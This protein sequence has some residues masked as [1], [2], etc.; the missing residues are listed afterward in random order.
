MNKNFPVS[1]RT[2]IFKFKKLYVCLGL[3]HLPYFVCQKM[4]TLVHFIQNFRPGPLKWAFFAY[5][6]YA[7]NKSNDFSYLPTISLSHCIPKQ[8][9]NYFALYVVWYQGRV[10]KYSSQVKLIINAYCM[11]TE[12]KKWKSKI[13]DNGFNVLSFK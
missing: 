5:V 11:H 3:S 9:H 10:Y 8:T 2:Y 12:N 6:V 7:K 1:S 4:P 13:Q